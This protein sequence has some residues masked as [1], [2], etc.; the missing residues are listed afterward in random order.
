[1]TTTII[2]TNGTLPRTPAISIASVGGSKFEDAKIGWTSISWH[3]EVAEVE[4]E[5]GLGHRH[6]E[7]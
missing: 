2:C 1:M 7:C 6:V 4:R 3:L 5:G